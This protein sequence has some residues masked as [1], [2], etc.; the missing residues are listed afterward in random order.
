MS[1]EELQ[2]ALQALH[3]HPDGAVKKQA[4]AWL[5]AW[6]QSLG[7]W[8]V[9][10]AVLHDPGSGLEAQHFAAQTLRTKVQ[11]DFEE[12]PA[13]AAGALRDSLVE[14][15]LRA[16]SAP[17]RTQ[18]CLALAA[19]AAHMP[20]ERWAPAPGA[21][22]WLV[23]RL[24]AEPGPAALP[25]LLE[26][27]TVLP[28]VHLFF[29]FADVHA[30]HAMRRTERGLLALTHFRTGGRQ[31]SAAGHACMHACVWRA[32]RVYRAQCLKQEAGS[33]RP[34]VRPERRRQLAAELAAATPAALQLLSSVLAQ[35]PGVRQRVLLAFAEWLRMSDMS[36]ADA[37]ALA[38]H[39][40]TTA[41]LDGLSD[42]EA[43]EGA[44][45]ATVE[46]VYASSAGSAGEP[47]QAALPLVQRLVP[48]VLGLLPRFRAC[49]RGAHAR[50]GGGGEGGEVEDDDDEE[51]AK[52]M[53]RLFAEVGEAYTGLI[54]SG[55]GH[56]IAVF[57]I[58]LDS[59][60][61]Q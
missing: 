52:G 24:G 9:S 61:R 58:K 39:S 45:D 54:A 4:S 26:L 21:V 23:Q 55:T 60:D 57:L 50:E 20:P 36:P 48:A 31:Q 22:A 10:D 25:C 28:Q 42:P 35:H 27:L 6:Q 40:L 47:D 43:F 30:C 29:F 51:T 17:V 8:S 32:E 46:L 12:L 37:G 13:S 15:L 1:R 49:V 5:E 33:Y 19:L 59:K 7:A 2:A 16:G 11:R 14:L 38:A 53:A 56:V 18:L 34:S 44:V 3:H 41:A